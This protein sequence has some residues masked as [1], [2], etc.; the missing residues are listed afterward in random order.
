V[1]GDREEDVVQVGGVNRQVLD[2][3]AGVAQL[4]EQCA[5]RGEGAVAR[6]LQGELL[7]LGRGGVEQ[8]GGLV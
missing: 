6:H 1:A 4:L 5:Q 2:L 7:T 3:N 8:Y